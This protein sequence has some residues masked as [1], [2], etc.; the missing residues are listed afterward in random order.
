M[1]R[2]SIRLVMVLAFALI[3]THQAVLAENL[4]CTD[5]LGRT[6]TVKIPVSRAVI[7]QT[8]ELIPALGIWDKVVGIARFAYANDLIKATR[9]NIATAIPSVSAGSGL[10]ANMEMLLKLKPDVVITWAVKPEAVKFMEDRGL[11]A[12][13]IYPESL[14]ELVDVIRL[15]GRLFGEEKRAETT[16]AEM[17]AIFRLVRDTVSAI[18]SD[19]RRKVLWVGGKPTMVSGKIGVTNDLIRLIGG[20]NAASRVSPSN[21]DVP[22]ERIV[23]WNPDVIFI[24]GNATYSA[25]SI[26]KSSQWKPIKAVREG[27]VYK[28]PMWHTWSPRI[29][30]IVLWMAAKTYPEYFQNVNLE[31]KTNDFYQLIFGIPYAK[32]SRIE[33]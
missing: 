7:F 27:H 31:K 28:A 17:E 2:L 14:S 20:I 18:P 32:V 9:P 16:I 10:D 33:N 22:I 29:A 6:V 19:R 25:E 30:P 26:L 13:A 21:A 11:K 1:E 15:H 4:T 24:W 5:K 23:A 3:A 12:I 8:Y